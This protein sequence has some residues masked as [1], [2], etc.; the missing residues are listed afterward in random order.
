MWR[1]HFGRGAQMTTYRTHKPVVP[2]ACLPAT[3][4]QGTDSHMDTGQHILT[5]PPFQYQKTVRMISPSPCPLHG[6]KCGKIST[7]MK[8]VA[9]T[10][11][12]STLSKT[13][14]QGSLALVLPN[15]HVTKDV[16]S[17]TV[18]RRPWPR[19]QTCEWKWN[20]TCR[21]HILWR[22]VWMPCTHF[23]WEQIAPDLK[24]RCWR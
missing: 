3:Q 23:E 19:P 15:V 21:P 22:L 20:N 17:T 14:T 11:W 8:Q 2:G 12:S 24:H 9:K 10:T 4:W 6:G 16:T 13:S 5:P 1:I 7:L 18:K